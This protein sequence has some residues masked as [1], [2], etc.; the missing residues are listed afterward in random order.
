V[1]N[2]IGGLMNILYPILAPLSRNKN[3][4]IYAKR[5]ILKL[6]YLMENIC[7]FSAWS[8]LKIFGHIFALSVI[9]PAM[10]GAK[11][12]GLKATVNCF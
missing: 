9:M 8:L 2:G 10:K 5:P 6:L 12:Q 11:S 4:K 1:P 3:T 7:M